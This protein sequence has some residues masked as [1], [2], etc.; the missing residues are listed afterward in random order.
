MVTYEAREREGKGGGR[1]TQEWEGEEH[2]SPEQTEL[3]AGMAAALRSRCF[4]SG[5]EWGILLDDQRERGG[6][7]L[8]ERGRQRYAGSAGTRGSL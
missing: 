4:H 1:N 2:I 6:G 8:P 3:A 7:P 5:Q